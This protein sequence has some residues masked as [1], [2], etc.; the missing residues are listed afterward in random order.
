M[1]EK[2]EEKRVAILRVLQ[3]ADR[4]LGS[5]GITERL[6]AMGHDISERTVR[7]HLLDMDQA[8]LT[9]NLGRNGR[10]IT[11]RGLTELDS[12]RG[13]EK[14]GILSAKIDQMTYKMDFDLATRT[15]S[16][17]LNLSLIER[18][19]LERAVPLINDV[20]AAGYAMGKLMALFR[21]AEQVGHSLIPEGSVGIGTVCSITI[22]GVLVANGI[23]THS[24][25]GGLLELR[26][27]KPTRFAEFINYDGTT[28]DPLEIF[29]RSVMTDYVGA[30]RT[31]NGL[32]G[33]SFREVPADSRDHVLELDREMVK[34]G[35]GAISLIGWPGQSLLKIP[36]SEGR[37]GL[38]VVGGLNPVAIL[39]EQGI[40]V[41]RTGALAGLIDYNRLFPYEELA[42]RS[43]DLL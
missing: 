6:E 41:R 29:I 43:R 33:A 12:A 39:E 7:F 3:E 21:P 13:F 15:G 23:P 20:F 9:E 37:L 35:L 26:E 40:H 30:T 1:R 5:S 32:I 24:R 25:F 31:G 42:E 27:G 11:R 28:L 18:S 38:V 4:P 36:V 10:A 14:V 2:T 17:V 22:N 8:G 34:A 19:K 16:V